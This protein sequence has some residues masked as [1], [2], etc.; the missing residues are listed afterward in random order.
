MPL[1]ESYALF[2]LLTL[3]YRSSAFFGRIS[4]MEITKT[5]TNN[6]PGTLSVPG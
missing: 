1:V 6:T 3:D 2:M 4:S 5:S